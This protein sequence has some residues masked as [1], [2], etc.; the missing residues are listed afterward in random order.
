MSL[1]LDKRASDLWARASRFRSRGEIFGACIDYAELS[2]LL[3]VMSIS[4]KAKWES[5]FASIRLDDH[6]VERLRDGAELAGE[7]LWRVVSHSSNLLDEEVLLI[8]SEL[9]ALSA[10]TD[11]AIKCFGVPLTSLLNKIEEEVRDLKTDQKIRRA[12]ERCE[13]TIQR[14]SRI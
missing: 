2:K 4:A 11:F 9:R 6:E 10:V 1:S 14:N 5:E 12:F 8:I 13:A 3:D 7:K